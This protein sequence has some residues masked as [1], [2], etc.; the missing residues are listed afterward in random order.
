MV[1]SLWALEI[2]LVFLVGCNQVHS[3]T[4]RMT[5]TVDANGQIHPAYLE[6][7]SPARVTCVSAEGRPGLSAACVVNETSLGPD[8]SIVVRE[9]VFLWCAGIAPLKCTANVEHS[10]HPRLEAYLR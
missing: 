4:Q 7:T 8:E 6:A 5:A 10:V 2:V 3:S 1:R 9:R